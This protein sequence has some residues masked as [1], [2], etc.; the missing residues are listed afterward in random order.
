MAWG[1]SGRI[2]Q[3]FAVYKNGAMAARVHD[4]Q[5]PKVELV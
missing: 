3:K 1:Y 5:H 4:Q 2:V